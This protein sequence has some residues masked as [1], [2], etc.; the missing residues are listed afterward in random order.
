[1]NTAA[2]RPARN[3]SE[4]ISAVGSRQIALLF[5]SFCF[6]YNAATALHELGHALAAWMTGGAVQTMILH[7]FSTSFTEIASDPH[8]RITHIAGVV[9]GPAV[10]LLGVWVAWPVRSA[11][12]MPIHLTGVTA[13]ASSGIYLLIGTVM[14]VGDADD[15]LRMG[16]PAFP[17]ILGGSL[18]LAG[19]L[20]LATAILP[21]LGIGRQHSVWRRIVLFEGSIVP[22]LGL[23]LAYQW[24]AEPDGVA[25][26]TALI[27]AGIGVIAL[28]AIASRLLEGRLP[29]FI[30][31]PER[32]PTSGA[33]ASSLVLGCGVVAVALLAL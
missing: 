22:Y 11:Y 16:V 19:S 10:A 21:L 30:R 7:P 28:V 15:L 24:W 32:A 17:L 6:G 18:L 33:V 2:G 12:C 4:W 26:W 23:I 29:G 31:V 8:P 1:M 27:A 13:L 14:G 20:M 25:G 9:F 3:G 5:G